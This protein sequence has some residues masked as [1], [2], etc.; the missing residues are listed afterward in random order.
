M[1]HFKPLSTLFGVIHKE[2]FHIDDND[3]L[4]EISGFG[5]LTVNKI[6]FLT[7]RGHSHSYGVDEAG[8]PFLFA[9]PGH[10]F[11]AVA[12][13]YDKFLDYL[14]VRTQP[15]PAEQKDALMKMACI[16]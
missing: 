7:Y 3:S 6:K 10:T 5:G 14:I 13:G 1:T 15:L 11:G 8:V 16:Q 4:L 9:F 2:T 12:G